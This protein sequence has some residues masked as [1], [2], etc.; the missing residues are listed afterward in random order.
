[1]TND[2]HRW[3][4]R[5]GEATANGG[6]VGFRTAARLFTRPQPVTISMIALALIISSYLVISGALVP[7]RTIYMPL[8][9]LDHALP[10][11]PAWSVIYLSL[12]LAALPPVCVVHQQE[13]VQRTVHAFLA[14]W[15]VAYVFFLVY[16]II[17]P[18]SSA[19]TVGDSFSS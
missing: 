10:V 17:G 9:W 2:L 19:K 8:V 12:F 13:L 3:T 14:I 1:M 7:G 18:R 16:P 11:E 6:S 4:T 5:I 15:R